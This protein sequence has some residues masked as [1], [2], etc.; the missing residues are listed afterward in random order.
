LERCAL[1]G[2]LR[3]VAAREKAWAAS[4]PIADPDQTLLSFIAS[5]PRRSQHGRH[6]QHPANSSTVPGAACQ[7]VTF[8][9][10]SHSARRT[11][12]VGVCAALRPG[13]GRHEVGEKESIDADEDY[14]QD[15]QGGVG[16]RVV[17]AGEQYPELA[18]HDDTEW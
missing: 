13:E 2:D 4:L 5:R 6:S 8:S 11:R 1:F 12:P 17:I 9:I 10:S 16:H 15:R 18:P 3:G 7:S 14:R